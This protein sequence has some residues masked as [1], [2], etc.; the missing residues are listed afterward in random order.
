MEREQGILQEA[1]MRAAQSAT[2]QAYDPL[3][4]F[5]V[6]SGRQGV[7]VGRDD[8]GS[9]RLVRCFATGGLPSVVLIR[10]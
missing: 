6:S 3:T 8:S 4:H 10:R 5:R 9:L 2:A 7:F 1:Q